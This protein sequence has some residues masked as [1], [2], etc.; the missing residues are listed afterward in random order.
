MPWCLQFALLEEFESDHP[1]AQYLGT[2][3]DSNAN[4]QKGLEQHWSAQVRHKEGVKIG[5]LAVCL[6]S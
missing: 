4:A 5:L 1:V 2:I 6:W 3:D